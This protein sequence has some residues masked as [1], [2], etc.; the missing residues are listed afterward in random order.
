MDGILVPGLGAGGGCPNLRFSPHQALEE[1]GV[2]AD[3]RRRPR[4]DPMDPIKI[5]DRPLESGQGHC[6]LLACSGAGDV[7]FPSLSSG[8]TE[9]GASS[10]EICIRMSAG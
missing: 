8:P 9:G 1:K 10:L 3:D 2:P 7:R 4:R 5:F 6:L